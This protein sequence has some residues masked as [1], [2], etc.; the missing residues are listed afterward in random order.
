V[1]AAERE[2][3]I[4]EYNK[5]FRHIVWGGGAITVAAVTLSIIFEDEFVSIFHGA[6]SYAAIVILIPFFVAYVSRAYN[7]PARELRHRLPAGLGRSREEV[8]RRVLGRTSWVQLAAMI[9]AG[10]FIFYDHLAQGDLTSGWGPVW[11]VAAVVYCGLAIL[12]VY[13]K[14]RN[15]SDAR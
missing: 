8:S 2:R 1:T 7:A 3:F 13:R 11:L 14:W 15:R 10:G 4:A 6:E 12:A 9:L 5:R